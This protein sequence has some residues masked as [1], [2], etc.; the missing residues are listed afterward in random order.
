MVINQFLNEFEAVVVRGYGLV[1]V[2]IV[3]FRLLSELWLLAIFYFFYDR[4]RHDHQMTGSNR[5]AFRFIN[6][7]IWFILA[8]LA[9]VLFVY[10]IRLQVG[11]IEGNYFRRWEVAEVS[12]GLTTAYDA[13]H[14]VAAIEVLALAASRVSHSPESSQGVVTL[15]VRTD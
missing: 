12:R 15:Y 7:F 1:T 2:F 3:F 5:S 4:F 13:M 6:G 8:A 9:I 10:I 14:L 11:I